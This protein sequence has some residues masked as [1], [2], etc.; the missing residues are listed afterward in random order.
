MNDANI[1]FGILFLARHLRLTFQFAH[2]EAVKTLRAYETVHILFPSRPFAT[3]TLG[4]LSINDE[5]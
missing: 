4:A 5:N 1:K 2:S 3:Q